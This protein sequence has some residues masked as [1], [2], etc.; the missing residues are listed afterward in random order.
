MDASLRAESVWRAQALL[1]AAPPSPRPPPPQHPLP[2]ALPSILVDAPSCGSQC[3][4]CCWRGGLHGRLQEAL[5]VAEDAAA[6][7]EAVER[8]RQAAERS[9][10]EA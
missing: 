5:R 6:A 7:L 10:R 2:A 8:A 1:A 4:A 3:P 9:A